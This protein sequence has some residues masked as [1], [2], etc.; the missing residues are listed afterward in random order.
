MIWTEPSGRK[1]GYFILPAKHCP[2]E[3]EHLTAKVALERSISVQLTW[4]FI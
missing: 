1:W 4:Y 3:K 2:Y